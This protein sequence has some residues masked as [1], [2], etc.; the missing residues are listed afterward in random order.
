HMLTGPLVDHVL[1]PMMATDGLLA[2]SIGHIIGVG[3][4]RGMGLLLLL[5]GLLNILAS[6]IAYRY[7][8]IR[9]VE[10]ELPDAIHPNLGL[11][12]SSSV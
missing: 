7:P 4:G 11:T 5:M 2:G 9:R 1:E 8:P 3:P 6:F 12:S 10:K